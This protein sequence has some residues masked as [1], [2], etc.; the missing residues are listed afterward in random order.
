MELWLVREV[1][2]WLVGLAL[3]AGLPA[4]VLGCDVLIH[5]TIPHRRL[6]R[7]NPV[8][9]AI[10]AVVGVAYAV[11]IGLCVVTL[12]E[13]Q[14]D[15]EHTVRREATNVTALV[16]SSRVFGPDAQRRVT[17]AVVAYQQDLVDEWPDRRAG[18]P[19]RQSTAGLAGLADTIGALRP[20]TEAQRAFVE[21]AVNRIGLAQELHQQ[22]LSE[23]EDRQMSVVMWI[24]VLGATLAILGMCLLFGLD[25]SLLRRIL[26][27]LTSAV[28]ATNL[29]LIVEMN[30]PYQGSFAVTPD[31]YEQVVLELRD[32]T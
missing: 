12:W 2:A 9:G 19:G 14:S 27:A 7:H 15:A 3:I 32:G 10:V 8:T 26:L 11:I 31:S 5:R 13:G 25:D 17:D 29:Y 22:S 16:A 28:I 24:G 18:R 1:P 20:D 23:A 4:V 6:D 30:Y 21:Q